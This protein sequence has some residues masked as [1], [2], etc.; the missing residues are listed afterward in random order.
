MQINERQR[1]AGITLLELLLWLG[2]AVVIVGIGVWLIYGRAPAI[3]GA[4]DF[5]AAVDA[6]EATITSIGTTTPTPTQCQALRAD[7]TKAQ[8]AFQTMQQ[9]GKLPANAA[10]AAQ[11]RLDKLQN[12]IAAH[13]A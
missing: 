10:R 1:E 3:P 8:A 2:L 7:F 13:C 4:D 9:S 11:D 5:K 6:G 12:Y